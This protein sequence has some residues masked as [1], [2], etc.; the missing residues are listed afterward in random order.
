VGVKGIK[1][2]KL[3]SSSI[4]ELKAS[5][6]NSLS[7]LVSNG[8]TTFLDCRES[9][10][11]GINLLK[12]SLKNFPLRALILGRPYENDDINEIFHS[13]NGFA[14][15]DI[16]SINETIAN[17]ANQLK[18]SSSG[19]LLSIHVSESEDVVSR[20]YS[21]FNRSDINLALDLLELNFVVHATY[22]EEE[23]LDLL[24]KNDVGVICCPH[25]N[26][27][28]GTSFPPIKQI[29]EKNLILGLG[30]DNIMISN[31]NPFRLMSFTLNVARSFGQTLSPKDI[32]KATTVNPGL[33]FREKIG[34]IK[35]GFSAD[36][37]GINLCNQNVLYSED[38]YT[39]IT[40]RAEV[41][42]IV[43]QMLKGKIIKWKD[44]R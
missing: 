38:V 36:F 25:S 16:F 10:L 14:F 2:K 34:Q 20:S 24:K 5:I 29:L 15:S 7:I 31:P 12:N 11:L 44:Q 33:I 43:F 21:E 37:I 9:G 6:T 3:N 13:C 39:A 42:D 35:E 27:Y 22:A 40:L 41:S 8:Y 17:Q 4:Q 19:S 26:M 30:T 28:F 18:Q 32:L 1:H 23:D